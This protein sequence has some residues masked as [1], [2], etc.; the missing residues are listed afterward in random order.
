MHLHLL[1]QNLLDLLDLTKVAFLSR[2]SGCYMGVYAAAI[3]C[4][5]D[6]V[7]LCV[8]RSAFSIRSRSLRRLLQRR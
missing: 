5:M 7:R 8:R 1:R 2:R 3:R 4:I 6:W